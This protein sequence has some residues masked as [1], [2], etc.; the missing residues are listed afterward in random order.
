MKEFFINDLRVQLLGERVVRIEQ[1]TGGA[2]CDDNTY[3]IPDRKKFVGVDGE[4]SSQNGCKVITFNGFKLF[5]PE[6]GG[7][8]GVYLEAD[9]ERRYS[10]KRIKNTGE[11][12]LPEKT[13]Y[14]YALA[15]TPRV[16]LPANGYTSGAVYTVKECVNDIYLLV[17]GGDHK[18]LRAL[19]VELTGRTEMVR[20]STLGMWNSRYYKH[21]DASAR[22]LIREYAAHGV[23]LDNMVLDTDWRKASDRGI[24]Y[25]VDDE[26]FPDMKAFFS[27]A[28]ENGVEIM[29]ND[30]PEPVEGAASLFAQSEI[31]YREENLKAHLNAGLDY[32]WY[33]RNWHTKLKSPTSGINPESFGSYLFHEITQNCFKERAGGKPCRRPVIMSNVDDIANG[34]YV[35]ISDSASHRYSVQWTGDIPSDEASI[36]TEIKNVLL[37]GNSCITYVNSDCGGH[38]GNPTKEEF[39]RWMQFGAFSPVFRPHCTNYV[40]RFREPWCYDEETLEITRSFVQMRYRL[41]PLIYKNAYESYLNGAPLLKTLSYEYVGDKKTHGVDDEYLLG[42][43]LVAPMH[44]VAPAKLA[45]SNYASPVKAVYYDGTECKGEPLCE[46]EY[47]KLDLYWRHVSPAPEVPVYNFS[48]TFETDLIF[49]QDVEL[50]VE[51]DDGATVYVDGEKRVEDKSFHSAVKNNAGVLKA[52]EPHHLKIEYFQGGGEASVSLF[53]VPV[54]RKY[55][56]V[57]RKIYLPVGEWVDVNAGKVHAGGKYLNKKCAYADMPLFVRAGA[58][59]PLIAEAQNTKKQTWRNVVYDYYPSVTQEYNGYLYEDD[60]TTVAYKNGAVRISPLS[61]GYD[62]QKGAFRLVLGKSSGKYSDGLKNRTVTVKFH[63]LSGAESVN[64]VCVNGVE[65]PFKIKR[66]SK[67]AEPF[68]TAQHSR[69]AATLVVKLTQPITDEA[70]IEFYKHG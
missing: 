18:I 11:L 5:V 64:K 1:L 63:V 50:I 41:L 65:T 15:D 48:A 43:I 19:Y 49:K 70:V 25:E 22:A 12:P 23:P 37:A 33:D 24:G 39:I 58:V 67:K 66:K 62:A 34:N 16:T 36:A 53:Y 61:A 26:I 6:N 4:I 51:T 68:T 35:G 69:D 29:F 60:K 13:P 20:L 42:E 2:F 10:Y 3:F 21:D 7:L 14:V 57:S 40:T 52:G 55:S 9:G 27:F 28:H 59:I 47:K 56:L 44:G 31:A 54:A 17:C 30:H 32:W 45:P 46:T 38:T 8:A